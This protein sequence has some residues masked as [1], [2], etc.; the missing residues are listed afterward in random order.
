MKKTKV[1]SPKYA[2][3]LVSFD[4]PHCNNGKDKA[5]LIEPDLYMCNKCG[6]FF[7]SYEIEVIK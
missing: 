3:T 7:D 6:S 4:C 5:Y 2:T 1:K